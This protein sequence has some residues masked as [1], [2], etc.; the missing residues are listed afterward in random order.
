MASRAKPSVVNFGA[1]EFNPYTKELR[2]EGMRVRLEGQPLAVLQMLLDRPGELVTREELQKKLWPADTF[3]DFEHSL[4]AAVKRLRERLNDSADQPRFVET[5]ARRGYRFVAPVNGSVAERESEKAV[6]VPVESQL[7]TPVRSRVRRLWV[8]A[9]AAVCFVGIALWG[10]RQSRNRP[11]TPAIPAVR[12]LAVLPLENLSGDPSQQYLADGMTE[13]LIGRLSMIHGLRVISRTSVMHFKNTD[14]SVPEIA[15]ILGADAIV[16]GSVIREGNRIRVHAQLIRGATDEH[17]WSETYDRELRDVLAL[18]SEVAQS[19]AEKVEA[20][21]TKEEHSRLVASRPVAPEVYESF[22]KGAFTGD[23]SRAGVERSIAYFEDAIKKDPTFAPAY[24]GLAN[25]YDQYG[26]PGI[27]GAPPNEVR[28]KVISAIRKALELD[29]EL[30]VAHDLLAGIY[31]EQWQWNDAEAEYRRA[32]KLNPNDSSAHLGFARWLLCQGHT[33]EAQ[34]WA[35]R[36]RELDPFG[37]TGNTMGWLLFQSR[38]FDES[39]REFRSDLAVHPDDGSSYWLLGFALIANNQASQAIGVLEK[40]LVLTERSPGVI[41]V[42]VRAYAHAGQRTKALRLLG[43]LERRQKKGYVPAAAFVN[44][45]LGLGDNERALVWLQKAY[46]EHS[47]ILQFAKV[48]PFLDPLRSDPR[49]Q[50]LLHRVGLDEA[51]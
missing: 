38:H 31:Q 32:L 50:F 6:P 34:Q 13:E 26:T 15:K 43:E 28:P 47:A 41:G 1:Y 9:A 21:V 10:W 19:I 25:A 33:E 44:A 5:L 23:Y 51:R 48:H 7:P 8:F 4:N 39:I 27:G 42:L 49:F 2:K 17:F 16:E 40:A 29:P 11:V 36:A 12:S 20:S 24:V 45:Y 35:R 18:Q 14:R 22:L 30:P 3:V 46:D 37:M